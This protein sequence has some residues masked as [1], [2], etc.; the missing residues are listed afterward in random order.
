MPGELSLQ[1]LGQAAQ[2]FAESA[3]RTGDLGVIAGKDLMA[4]ALAHAGRLNKYGA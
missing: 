3:C 2:E 4:L 1:E